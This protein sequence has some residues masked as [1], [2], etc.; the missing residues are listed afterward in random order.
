MILIN[1]LLISLDGLNYLKKL[2]SQLEK[3]NFYKFIL[4]LLY[5]RN[6]IFFKTFKYSKRNLIS[7]GKIILFIY[8]HNKILYWI[9]SFLNFKFRKTNKLL[10]IRNIIYINNHIGKKLLQSILISLKIK[11]IQFNVVWN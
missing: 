10:M 7:S 4:L 11:I 6:A 2:K 1:I 3:L 5:D 8:F 9:V